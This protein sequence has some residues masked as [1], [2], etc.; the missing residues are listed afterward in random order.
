LAL[1]LVADTPR[2]RD[3]CVAGITISGIDY[4]DTYNTASQVLERE[5]C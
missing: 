3:G 4:Q 2:R 5:R 1:K